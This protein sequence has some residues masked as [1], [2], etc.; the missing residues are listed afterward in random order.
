M[1]E[2]TLAPPIDSDVKFCTAE[3]FGDKYHG[4]RLGTYPVRQRLQESVLAHGPPWNGLLKGLRARTDRDAA[5]RPSSGARAGRLA[6]RHQGATETCEVSRECRRSD[7]LRKHPNLQPT[8]KGAVVA[9]S[10]ALPL[11]R[12]GASFPSGL[13]LP[14]G[15][16]KAV[17]GMIFAGGGGCAEKI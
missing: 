5:G 16:G 6:A 4:V 14:P 17:A 13:A 2:V 12:A 15:S 8:Y 3:E 7:F 10:R 9:V 11:P 1:A